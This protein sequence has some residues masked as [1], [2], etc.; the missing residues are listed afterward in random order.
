MSP[1]TY[2]QNRFRFGQDKEV[3]C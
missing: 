1:I 3:I 2:I